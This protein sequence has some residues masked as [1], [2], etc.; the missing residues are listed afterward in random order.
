MSQINWTIF[1]CIQQCEE[2]WGKNVECTLNIKRSATD[3]WSSFHS[4]AAGQRSHTQRCVIGKNAHGASSR[5]GDGLLSTRNS[6]RGFAGTIK[7]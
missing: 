6:T 1:Y 7:A 3:L 5:H 2:T 4:T